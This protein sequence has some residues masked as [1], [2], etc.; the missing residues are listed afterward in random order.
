MPRAPMTEA[1]VRL[2]RRVAAQLGPEAAEALARAA[3]A[4]I[5]DPASA[6]A[7]ARLVAALGEIGRRAGG[8]TAALASTAIVGVER[9]WH[10]VGS[11]ERE[12]MAARYAIP[13]HPSGAVRAAALEAYLGLTDAAA[14]VAVTANDPERARREVLRALELEARMLRTE[15]LG[16]GER[17]AA[18]GANTRAHATVAA[19]TDTPMSATRTDDANRP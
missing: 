1:L 12:L 6:A 9:C 17:Q 10:S 8:V 15:A 13:Q 2:V 14:G 5:T 4:W 18:L 16:P 11:W 7:R 19:G 3:R